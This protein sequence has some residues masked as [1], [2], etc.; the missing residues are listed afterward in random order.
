MS[1]LYEVGVD[2]VTITEKDAARWASIVA[3]LERQVF[4]ALT[5]LGHTFE[6]RRAMGYTGVQVGT[7]FTGTRSDSSMLR[8]SGFWA[9]NVLKALL[10]AEIHP[11]VTRIDLQC[12]IVFT[13]DRMLFAEECKSAVLYHQETTPKR[14]HPGVTL[15]STNGRGDTLQ[16]GSRSSEV[17]CRIYDKWREQDYAYEPY[18]WRFEVEAKGTA[19]QGTVSWLAHASSWQQEVQRIVHGTFQGRGIDEPVLRQGRPIALAAKRAPTDDE[20]RLRWITEDVAP[21]VRK[22]WEH[23]YQDELLALFSYMC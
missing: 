19:A 21:T 2:Y 1:R 7:V 3:V 5:E 12:T 23:G 4:P 13:G 8:V 22:L 16:I 10:L 17:F 15:I 9:E 6:P 20:K 11:H 18:A 14:S